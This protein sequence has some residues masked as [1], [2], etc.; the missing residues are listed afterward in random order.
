MPGSSLTLWFEKP[1]PPRRSG[2][3]PTVNPGNQHPNLGRDLGLGSP[4]E[5]ALNGEGIGCA[6][7]NTWKE[8]VR[9]AMRRG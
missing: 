9:L 1:L 8:R 5:G 7:G 4:R 2:R 3:P 6:P